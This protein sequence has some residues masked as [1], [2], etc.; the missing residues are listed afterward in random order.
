MEILDSFLPAIPTSHKHPQSRVRA[1]ALLLR[2]TAAWQ[3]RER[4]LDCTQ[5]I[6]GSFLHFNQLIGKVWCQVFTFHASRREGLTLRGPDTDRI[7]KSHKDRDNRLD[8]SGLDALFQ[9]WS[10]H[11]EAHPAGNAVV[12][13]LDEV[14]DETWESCLQEALLHLG[15]H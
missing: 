2:W 4:A 14:P 6:H 7:R 5:S 9:A 13:F 11:P 15:T 3:G 12:F 1:E 8:P 10:A